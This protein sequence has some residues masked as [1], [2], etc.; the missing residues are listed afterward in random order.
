MADKVL[1]G[2]IATIGPLTDATMSEEDVRKFLVAEL[3]RWTEVTKE[4]GVLP[5]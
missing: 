1:S 3:A 2:R 4:I 5:E